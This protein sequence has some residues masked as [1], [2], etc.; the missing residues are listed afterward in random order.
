MSRDIRHAFRILFRNPAFTAVAV[1]T[2]ALG[3]GTNTA[4]FSVIDAVLLRPLPYTNHERVFIV[5]EVPFRFTKTG[6]GVARV[7][8]QSPVFAGVGLY[9]NGGLNLGGEPAERVRAAGVTPGFFR[10]LGAPFVLGRGFSD[11]DVART[12]EI[13][14]ISH[15]LWQRR[16][17]AN[18]NLVGQSILLN[19]K[20]FVVSGVL[21]DRAEF[22]EASDVW[23]PSGSD[24]QITGAAFAPAVVARLA[25]GVTLQHAL[26]EVDRINDS[27]GGRDPNRPDR[28]ATARPI[29]DEL[30]G[31]VRPI[32]LLIWGAVTLVLLVACANAANLLLARMAARDREFAVRRAI[33]ASSYTLARQIGI[34]SL[35]LALLG[36]VAALPAAWLTLQASRVLLPATLHGVR[37]VTMSVRTLGAT[38]G[39]AALAAIAA[40]FAPLLSIRGQSAQDALRAAGGTS[41]SRG[42]R[43]FRSA[44]VVVQ[45]AVALVLLA[46]AVAVV[47]TVMRLMAVDLGARGERALVVQLTLPLATYPTTERSALFQE[48]F[49]ERVRALPGVEAAGITSF[50][51]GS[52]EIGTGRMFT[53][54]TSRPPTSSD[55]PASYLSASPGYFESLGIQRIAGRAFDAIDT[56][57]SPP[58]AIVNEQIGR[59]AGLTA[60]DLVGRELQIYTRGTPEKLTI[61]GVVQ[62]VRLRGPESQANAQ[63]YRPLAQSPAQGTTYV[64]IT[65]QQDPSGL[66]SPVRAAAAQL[67]SNLPLYS[68][69]TFDEIRREYLASRRFAMSMMACFGVLAAMLAGIGLYGVIA[70]LVQLRTR[71]IGIRMALGASAA[72]VRAAV[73]RT[74]LS[75]AGWGALVG[76]LATASLSRILRARVPGL[77]G[78]DP[79]SVTALALGLLVV[80][81]TATWLPARRATRVDPIIALRWNESR[82]DVPSATC[83]VLCLRATCDVLTTCYVQGARAMCHVLTHVARA[84]GTCARRK[85]VAQGT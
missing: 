45:V 31:H 79:L 50:V 49:L 18:P 73:M 52:T 15:R 53:L 5:S 77:E 63:I 36:A 56:P 11:D 22:P 39:F 37:D 24:R 69:R 32:V 68:V 74:G 12:P 2:L 8:E 41:A 67:D 34:E 82:A 47:Q 19:G 26:A 16:F 57:G 80:A 81:A 27:R 62:D 44:L 51:P 35:V 61:V 71:E 60:G 33:G 40:G 1:L 38:F 21:T 76:A 10:A 14:V 4:V 46:G 9:A 85:H 83:N 59:M 25:E 28:R 72:A 20:P 43:H 70:Y 48:E 17:S 66:V 84:R 3:I 7:I 29:G 23:I 13:A 6:M 55:P 75:L 42:W 54:D 58:V 65:A 30:V 64:T 78:I